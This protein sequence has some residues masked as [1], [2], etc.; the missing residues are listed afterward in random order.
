MGKWRYS[1]RSTTALKRGTRYRSMVSFM[2][3]RFTPTERAWRLAGLR[4]ERNLM[5]LLGIEP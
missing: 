4:E 1:T 2:P 3:G 5:P